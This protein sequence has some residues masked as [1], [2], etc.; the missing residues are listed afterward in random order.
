MSV[1]RLPKQAHAKRTS[2]RCV[3]VGGI[4]CK[5]SRARPA[6]K[7]ALLSSRADLLRGL[8]KDAVIVRWLQ[9]AR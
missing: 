6:V 7:V 4:H 1:T 5:P 3:K 2:E 8:T 9:L